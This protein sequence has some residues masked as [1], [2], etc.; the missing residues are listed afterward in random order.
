MLPTTVQWLHDLLDQHVSARGGRDDPRRRRELSSRLLDLL[1][2][3]PALPSVDS[4]VAAV[5]QTLNLMGRHPSV[6]SRSEGSGGWHRRRERRSS[7]VGGLSRGG[8]GG[9]TTLSSTPRG[10][11]L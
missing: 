4:F 3:W 1:P 9:H 10:A 5:Q 7:V 6:G 11:Q 8:R 2:A